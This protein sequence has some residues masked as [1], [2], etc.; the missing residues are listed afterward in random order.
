[1][2]PKQVELIE[3]NKCELRSQDGYKYVITVFEDITKIDYFET[4][5]EKEN[6][7][8]VLKQTYEFPSCHDIQICEK[9]IEM[10]KSL[11]RRR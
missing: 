7:P 5:Y 2:Y 3:L 1:M 4:D 11:E 6:K 8:L 9:I 10:R